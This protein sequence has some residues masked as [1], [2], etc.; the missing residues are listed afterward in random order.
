MANL[1]DF[2]QNN[3]SGISNLAVG[4]L[5]PERDQWGRA[6]PGS[7]FAKGLQGYNA[8]SKQKALADPAM[9]DFLGIP[10]EFKPAIAANPQLIMPFLEKKL[11]GPEKQTSDIENYE[12]YEKRMLDKGEQPKDFETWRLSG[13]Q[14]E[15]GLRPPGMTEVIKNFGEIAAGLGDAK[16]QLGQ[17]EIIESQLSSLP[18]DMDGI[19]RWW[20]KTAANMGL[21]VEGGNSA[22]AADAMIS[23]MVP[24][25]R[26]EGSGSASDKD[27][28]LFKAGLQKL[29]R[30]KEGNALVAASLKAIAADKAARAQLARD[31]NLGKITHLQADEAM[32]ELPDPLAR[33]KEYAKANPNVMIPDSSDGAPGSIPAPPPGSVIIGQ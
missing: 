5:S 27:M 29:T 14:A 33:F 22:A 17:I 1:L 25:S 6:V 20:A 2:F 21:E 11:A 7:G 12:F 31:A 23:K 16:R 32:S 28:D 24:E 10:E 15:G 30:T 4:L 18:D 8:A 26:P 3:Q 9:L 13:K 19:D